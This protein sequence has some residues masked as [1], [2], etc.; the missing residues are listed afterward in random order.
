[1]AVT[2]NESESPFSN[3]LPCF[4]H[5]PS[6]EI[7]ACAGFSFVGCSTLTDEPSLNANTAPM[8]T[9]AVGATPTSP[10]YC[11]LGL[12]TVLRR[13]VRWNL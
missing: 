6:A 1:M 2:N 12:H 11:R 4:G 9:P 7:P 3:V 5:I 13:A 8:A 10:M